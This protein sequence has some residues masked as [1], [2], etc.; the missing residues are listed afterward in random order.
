MAHEDVAEVLRMARPSVCSKVVRRMQ[1][2]FHLAQALMFL[3]AS[4]AGAV[5]ADIEIEELV[6]HLDKAF[7]VR[8]QPFARG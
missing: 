1:P 7:S 3:P 4:L 2:D 6:N 8:G 5:C